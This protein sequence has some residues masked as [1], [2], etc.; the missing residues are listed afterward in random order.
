MSN[1]LFGLISDM[2]GPTFLVLYAC[3]IGATLAICW[4]WVQS[5]DKTS[6]LPPLPI[7]KSVNAYQIAF[8]RGGEN[9]LLRIMIFDLIQRGYLTP[10]WC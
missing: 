5:L 10:C 8:L 3:V 4:V 9:E 2:Y 7:P 1:L 6:N